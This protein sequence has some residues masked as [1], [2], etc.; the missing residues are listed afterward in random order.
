[1]KTMARAE[2]V[3]ELRRRIR[4]VRPDSVRRWGRMNVHQMLCHVAD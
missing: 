4:Q 1:M 3:E 2:E